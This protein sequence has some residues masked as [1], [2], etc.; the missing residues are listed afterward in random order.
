MIE[1]NQWEKE[2]NGV[3]NGPGDNRDQ[4]W[5]D[6]MKDKAHDIKEDAKDA[7]TDSDSE[8]RN[9]NGEDFTYGRNSREEDLDYESKT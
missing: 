7:F 1:R 4:S 6:S 8:E 2:N 9:S 3:T 5:V